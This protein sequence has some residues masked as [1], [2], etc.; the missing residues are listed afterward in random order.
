MWKM[1]HS[2]W[3]HK[4]TGMKKAKSFNTWR[5][6]W[7]DQFYVPT[8][9]GLLTKKHLPCSWTSNRTSCM[10]MCIWWC[11]S[12]D[13]QSECYHA[14]G[15]TRTDEVYIDLFTCKVGDKRSNN[16]QL[17]LMVSQTCGVVYEPIIVTV[18]SCYEKKFL[19][20]SVYPQQLCALVPKRL[21]K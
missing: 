9:P 3:R 1:W 8:Q 11:Q 7:Q 14:A 21:R 12:S 18:S 10:H 13:S 2:W 5:R 20:E 19:G 17:W 15:K 16:K 6:T 4:T